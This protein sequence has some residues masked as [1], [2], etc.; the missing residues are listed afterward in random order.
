LPTLKQPPAHIPYAKAYPSGVLDVLIG[1]R[2]IFQPL[3][4]LGLMGLWVGTLVI[5][6]IY[7]IKAGRGDWGRLPS[8]R[9]ISA[10]YLEDGSSGGTLSTHATNVI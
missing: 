3:A 7:A 9:Q 6:I 4:W 8:D 5:A 1:R 10:K 2:R